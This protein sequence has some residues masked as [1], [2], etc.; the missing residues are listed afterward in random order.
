MTLLGWFL[1]ISRV[2]LCSWARPG[3]GEAWP[4]APGR[5]GT[6][7][8]GAG[9]RGVMRHPQVPSGRSVSC[10]G[11]CVGVGA[12]ATERAG[13]DGHSGATFRSPSTAPTSRPTAGR[14]RRATRSPPA[15]PTA[16]N[17]TSRRPPSTPPPASS[18]PAR[19]TTARW[20]W[21]AE[22]GPASIAPPMAGRRGPTPCCRATPPTTRRRG[23]PARCTSAVSPTRATLS[24]PGTGTT[25]CSTWATPSTGWR[26]RTAAS[27]SRRTTRTPPTTCAPWSSAG[28]AGAQRQVQRQDLHRGRPRPR[29]PAR[30]QRVCR[31]ERLPGPQRQQRDRVR[32]VDGPRPDLQPPDED[33]RGLHGNQ[34]PTSR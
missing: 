5:H 10:L 15:A 3:T 29:Q 8:V 26:P 19:T 20:S 30:R 9:R 32:P 28:D 17:R 13:L 22:P 25:G 31:L 18:C 16:V 34:S 23:W 12:G 2:V 14:R 1:E 6:A 7:P 24:R 27:G 33:L 21:P 11:G 4:T